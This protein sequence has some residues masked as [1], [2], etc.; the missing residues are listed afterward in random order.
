MNDMAKTVLFPPV[1]V[2]AASKLMMNW[3]KSDL[4]LNLGKV[5]GL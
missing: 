4:P 2:T 3:R 5:M 1:E